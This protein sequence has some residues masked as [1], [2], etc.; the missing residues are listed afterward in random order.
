MP[1]HK[2]K[3]RWTPALKELKAISIRQPYAWLMVNGYKDIENRKWAT[4][5]RGPVLIHAGTKRPKPDHMKAFL[6]AWPE[7]VLGY[8]GVIGVAEIADCVEKHRSKWFRGRYGW[9]L[10]KPCPL[11]FKACAGKLKFFVPEI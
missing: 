6:D 3:A 8:G 4:K 5:V 2:K 10:E 1:K 9:V 11:P 7:A